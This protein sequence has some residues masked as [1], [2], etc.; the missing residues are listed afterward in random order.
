MP[1]QSLIL[2][3]SKAII[4]AAW[5]DGELSHDEINSLKDLLLRFTHGST[6]APSLTAQEWV[7][8][9]MYIESPIDEAER[10]RLIQ[11]LQSVAWSKPEKE[12]ALAGLVEIMQSDEGVTE[13]EQAAYETI[14]STIASVPSGFL[15]QL[16]GLINGA[17]RRRSKAVAQAPSREDY[18]DDFVKNK[19]Y[20]TVCRRLDLKEGEW[21]ISDAALR[22]LSLA[23]GLM[24]RIAHVD[25]IVTDDELEMM[26]NVL[27]SDWGLSEEAAHL[28]A[29]IALSETGAAMDFYRLTREFF[30]STTE[31]ERILFL[32][33]LFAISDADGDISFDE[34]EEIRRIARSL[35]LSQQQVN[36]AKATIT[37]DRRVASE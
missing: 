25:K 10:T 23:G 17:L 26:V 28:V 13:A 3:L 19:I 32:D 33:V 29:E 34:I 22:K 16:G 20:Y 4:A 15:G 24:A 21:G 8:L 37:S 9:D 2:T 30:E 11:A 1:D 35:N 6:T 7:I 5:A 36:E 14:K 31:D 12:V 18:F 27:Q